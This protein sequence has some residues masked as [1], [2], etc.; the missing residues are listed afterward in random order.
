MF[1]NQLKTMVKNSWKSEEPVMTDH[2]GHFADSYGHHGID[3]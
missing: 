3:V 1:E 2:E